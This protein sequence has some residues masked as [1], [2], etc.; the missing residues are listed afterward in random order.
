MTKAPVL[1]L[2]IFPRPFIVECD[3]SGFGIGAVLR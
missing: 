2:P 1:A 3:A